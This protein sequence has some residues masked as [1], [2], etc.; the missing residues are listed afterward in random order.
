MFAWR[1]RDFYTG[2]TDLQSL[3]AYKDIEQEVKDKKD[4][5]NLKIKKGKIDFK[6]VWFKYKNKYV[7][8]NFDLSIKENE[9]IALVGH[10]GSGKTTLAKLLYRLYDLDKGKIL[11]DN[12]NIAEVKQKSLR[13]EMSIV[14]QEG[15]LFNDTIYN[16]LIFSKPNATKKEVIRA[17]KA[18]QF[19]SFVQSLP[20]K[21][22]TM[23]GERGIKLSGGEKQR[24]S[25]ARALLANRKILVLDEATSALDSK[26]EM[27]IQKALTKLMKGRTTIIIA[28][29]LSTIMHANKIIVM[30]KGKIIQIGKHRDL[31]KKKG[32]YKQLWELQEKGFIGE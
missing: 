13:E 18:A 16:N 9:K 1:V 3:I 5:N 28:H 11:I 10:S 24:L 8:K 29:R 2:V 25:I 30:D 23:V 27:Q 4:A 20:E 7:I 21:E 15:I 19:Y 26:T 22:N 17:L 31:I 6:N 32:T 12:K 14:P